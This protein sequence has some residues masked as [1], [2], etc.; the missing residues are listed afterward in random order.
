MR[1]WKPLIA[2]VMAWGF[3]SSMCHA[4]PITWPNGP[5]GNWSSWLAGAGAQGSSAGASGSSGTTNPP[6][7]L[8]VTPIVYWRESAAPVSSPPVAPTPIAPVPTP[9]AP[10]PTPIAPMPL[11]PPSP[12]VSMPVNAAPVSTPSAFSPPVIVWPSASYSSAPVSAPV[13]AAAPA[14]V[15]VS[16]PVAPAPISIAPAASQPPVSAPALSFN[17]T[18]APVSPAAVA[19]TNILSGKP[20][21]AFINLGNGPYP[22]ASLITTGGAQPWYNSTGVATIFGGAPTLQQQQSFDAAILQRV[23]QTFAQSGVAIS[24]TSDP[25]Q[26]ALHTLSLVSNTVSSSLPTAIGMTQ[27]GANGF[28]FIDQS[29]KSAQSVDQLEWIVAHN[30]S[31]ELMLAFGVPENYDQTGKFVDARMASWSMM[32]SPSA[33]FS[34]AAAL[35]ISQAIQT[36]ENA[37]GGLGAQLVGPTANAVPEPATWIT[38][39][40]VATASL[41]FTRARRRAA[42]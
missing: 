31:H 10:V 28:S 17:Q 1:V 11:T 13:S 33:T 21:D 12:P 16:T 4:D 25:N 6:M 38:W 32:V 42:R 39:I 27:V 37:V 20:V 26:A 41:G 34:P 9:V 7:A 3:C 15:Q 24:L 23:Q 22:Q 2:G 14:P 18:A 19:S 35:A 5:W 36:Q 40:V 29:V 30:I 8:G